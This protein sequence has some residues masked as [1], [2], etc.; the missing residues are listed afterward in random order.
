MLN[1]FH[2]LYV[3]QLRDL[4]SAETQIIEALP[5][6]IENASN[7]D[8]RA[9]FEQHLAETRTQRDR[10]DVIF[11]SLDKDPGGHTCQAMKGIIKE[12]NDLI[13][14]THPIFGTD[15]PGPVRDAGLIASAQRVE[16]YEI[17][18]YGTV[19]EFARCLGR[20]QDQAALDA[21]LAEEK[22]TDQKLTRLAEGW[23]NAAAQASPAMAM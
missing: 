6:M 22:A 9:G 21:T 19:C 17:A 16:H 23:I 18:A 7:D 8:L 13:S 5:L 14:E 10:L 4:Y 12:A 20:T 15:T 1:T 2:D 11:Q 3:E